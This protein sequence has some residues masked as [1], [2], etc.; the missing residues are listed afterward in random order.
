MEHKNDHEHDSEPVQ[1]VTEPVTQISDEHGEYERMIQMQGVTINA[2]QQRIFRL[3]ME[4]V[5]LISSSIA[6][7]GG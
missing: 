6:N 2:L 4:I 3:E 1:P 5:D 7:D